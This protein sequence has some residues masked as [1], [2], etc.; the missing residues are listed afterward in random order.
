MNL[1]EMRAELAKVAAEIRA[2][3]QKIE[4]A[5]TPA[6]LVTLKAEAEVL[7]EKHEKLK[8]DIDNRPTLPDGKAE[9][10]ERQARLSSSRDVRYAELPPPANFVTVCQNI[11]DGSS[12]TGAEKEFF[13][14]ARVDSHSSN[15]PLELLLRP[16]ERAAALQQRADSFSAAPTDGLVALDKTVLPIFKPESAAALGLKMSPIFSGRALSI[17]IAEDSAAVDTKSRLASLDAAAATLTSV[18]LKPLRISASYGLAEEDLAE[19][20]D[21]EARLQDLLRGKSRTKCPSK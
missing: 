1:E 12:Q 11:L 20:S 15:F 6:E 14:E 18:K 10:L 13:D 9:D 2:H 16:G 5:K 3:A 17:L 8:A 21:L 19:Y 7:T 4:A